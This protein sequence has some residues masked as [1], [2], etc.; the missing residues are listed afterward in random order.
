MKRFLFLVNDN[1]H[2]IAANEIDENQICKI[3]N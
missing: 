1:L 3:N 2:K